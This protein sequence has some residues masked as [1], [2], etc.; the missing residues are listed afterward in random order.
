MKKTI[1]ILMLALLP[2][3]SRA[4]A[5]LGMT[6]PQIVEMHD[7]LH[8]FY[9]YKS[10]ISGKDSLL[11]VTTPFYGLFAYID[12]EDHICYTYN[13][14]VTDSAWSR[15]YEQMLTLKYF[16][17]TKGVWVSRYTVVSSGGWKEVTWDCVT[18]KGMLYYTRIRTT[19]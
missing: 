14:I 2:L 18:Y 15:G 7:S 8:S 11:I 9:L 3:C 4:Q 1:L 13:L 5:F 10:Q 16:E 19:P 6:L 12:G 17:K